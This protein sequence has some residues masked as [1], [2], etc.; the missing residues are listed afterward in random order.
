MAQ[1][2]FI[3]IGLSL[4]G[5]V[6]GA[7]RSPANPVGG[8]GRAIHAWMFGKDGFLREGP[9]GAILQGVF[10][11]TGANIM[12]RNMF[13]EGEPHWSETTFQGRPVYVLTHQPRT[14]W[15]RPGGTTFHFVTD[16]FESA[17]AQARASAGGKDVRVSGG[18]DVARQA[19]RAGVVDELTLHIAPVILGGGIRLFDGVGPGEFGFVQTA[20]GDACGVNHVTY[21]TR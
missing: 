5:F 1:K 20:V 8:G 18:A 15:A 3:D 2:V 14:P 19:M 21:Q 16:G 13:D 10:D 6:A 7:N 17:L 11:R 4:D 12:G 9:G